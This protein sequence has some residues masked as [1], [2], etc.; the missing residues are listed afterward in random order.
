MGI[1]YNII[2]IVVLVVVGVGIG[3]FISRKGILYYFFSVNIG[4]FL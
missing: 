3:W 4:K 1:V 2:I